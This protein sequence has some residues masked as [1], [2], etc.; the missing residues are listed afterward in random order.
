MAKRAVNQQVAK[1]IIE[2]ALRIN[3]LV[4]STGQDIRTINPVPA[5]IAGRITTPEEKSLG[6]IYKA[7]SS[8]IQGVLKYAERPKKK[9]LYF[10]DN[11]MTVSSIFMGYAASGAQLVIFQLGGGGLPNDAILYS[12]GGFVAPLLWTSANPKTLKMA[13]WKL[14][15][16]AGEIIE[17]KETIE[18]VSDRLYSTILDIASGTMTRTETINYVDPNQVYT[19]EP[20]F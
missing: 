13:G 1:A 10:V 8:P 14:D 18:K 3:E 5:N 15:F 19:T 11:W 7:G 2:A 6:A 20:V 12:S 9:G 17:G 4:K 16:Y